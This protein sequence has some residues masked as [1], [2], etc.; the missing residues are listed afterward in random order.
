MSFSK[1]KT[2]LFEIIYAP[3][4]QCAQVR[5][6]S[7]FSPPNN[8]RDKKMKSMHMFQW[9][10]KRIL[11]GTTICDKNT[12]LMV[13][14]IVQALLGPSVSYSSLSPLSPVAIKEIIL[15]T[16]NTQTHTNKF[17]RPHLCSSPSQLLVLLCPPVQ[18]KCIR[19]YYIVKDGS[20]L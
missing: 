1:K 18:L 4:F 7:L 8:A 3:S 13:S 16:S 2:D 9:I 11:I 19:N 15:S 5:D 6:Q 14:F 20:S 12:C 17:S 10:N